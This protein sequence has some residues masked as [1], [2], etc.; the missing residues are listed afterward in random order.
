MC[1]LRTEYTESVTLP[2]LDG[3]VYLIERSS[4]GGDGVAVSNG[5]T[6]TIAPG[7]VLISS[8]SAK[9]SIR[10]GG[11]IEA[12]G[13]ASQPIIFTSVSS[14]SGRADQTSWGGIIIMGRAPINAC[15]VSDASPGTAGC[16]NDVTIAVGSFGGDQPED[17][18][19]SLRYVQIRNAGSSGDL[20]RAPFSGLVLGGVGYQTTIDHVQVTGSVNSGISIYGGRVSLKNVAVTSP[21]RA[22]IYSSWGHRG[23][24]Q[25]VVVGRGPPE[26][27][28]DTNPLPGIV[29]TNEPGGSDTFPRT[30]T[31]IANLTFVSRSSSGKMIRVE[32]GADFALLNAVVMARGE[33]CLSVEPG[34]SW[35]AADPGIRELGRPVF[36]SVGLDCDGLAF[37]TTDS[38]PASELAAEFA[39]DPNNRAE[40]VS[41]LRSNVVN[42]PSE[43]ILTPTDPTVFNADPFVSTP[44]SA[45]NQLTMVS[46]VGAVSDE[47][48]TGFKGWTCNTPWATLDPL[49]PSC[50][51]QIM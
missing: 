27:T 40:F 10:A 36:R 34:A 22:G 29:A 37:D 43:S 7:V 6:L 25:F 51:D 46:Y 20:A 21:R 23:S 12:V 48:D 47:N 9:L 19:G 1:R 39:L 42:G 4:S 35:Q 38:V 11:R 28:T 15:R 26:T 3:I 8:F 30:Y 44:D 16:Y 18:S 17:N 41:T 32:H 5:A 24:L 2:K 33:S 31:R 14:I 49:G 50:A 13:T 45:P